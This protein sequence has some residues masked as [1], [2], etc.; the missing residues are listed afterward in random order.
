MKFKRG[1]IVKIDGITARMYSRDT[2]K[3]IVLCVNGYFYTYHNSQLYQC[4]P[5]NAKLPSI[6]VLKKRDQYYCKYRIDQ[7]TS[8]EYD[9]ILGWASY[10]IRKGQ[11]VR[12]SGNYGDHNPSGRIRY[13]SVVVSYY[14]INKP[15]MMSGKNWTCLVSTHEHKIRITRGKENDILS[16]PEFVMWNLQCG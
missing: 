15:L 6:R 3:F 4:K 1:K 7:N 11:N 5:T 16:D 14:N 13:D 9:I 2:H 12:V 10:I 8:L